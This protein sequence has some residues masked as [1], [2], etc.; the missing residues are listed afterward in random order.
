MK[1]RAGLLYNFELW[2]DF[3]V[4]QIQSSSKGAAIVKK[5]D[6][7]VV[8]TE[9]VPFYEMLEVY[10]TEVQEGMMPKTT[11]HQVNMRTFDFSKNR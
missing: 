3:T 9:F 5:V 11:T 4:K 2:P 10:K 1:N 8:R 7:K 6:L